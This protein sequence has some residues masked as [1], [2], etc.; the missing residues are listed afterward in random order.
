MIPLLIPSTI[1]APNHCECN[2]VVKKREGEE[3][4]GECKTETAGKAWCYVDRG[5]CSDATWSSGSQQFWSFLGCQRAKSATKTVSGKRCMFPFTYKDQRFTSCTTFDSDNGKPWCRTVEGQLEDCE[6]SDFIFPNSSPI[7]SSNL[8]KCNGVVKKRDGEK[9]RGECKTKTEGKTWCYVASV[10]SCSDA[11]WSSASEQF[12]SYQACQGGLSG[13]LTTS[14]KRCRFPFTYKGGS[15]SKCTTI[16]SANGKAWCQ[17]EDGDLEDCKEQQSFVGKEFQIGQ[18]GHLQC[19]TNRDC[20]DSFTDLEGQN[21]GFECKPLFS[22]N[23]FIVGRIVN[24]ET[25]N[26]NSNLEKSSV[27]WTTSSNATAIRF[28]QNLA[29]QTI[30]EMTRSEQS[31]GCPADRPCEYRRGNLCSNWSACGRLFGQ[32]SGG[33][34]ACPTHCL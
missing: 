24:T 6:G 15:F 17:N 10:G 21:T 3:P 33:H 12:W 7:A 31:N 19:Q 14:G 27:C 32:T 11:Q 29:G 13:T 22:D 26:S 8:C 25:S 9:T 2:G 28:S 5:S 34:L 4:R 18:S 16:E 23:D 30:R 20:P 1:L